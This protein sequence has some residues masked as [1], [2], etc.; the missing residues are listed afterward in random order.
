GNP[1]HLKDGELLPKVKC[2]EIDGG[3]FVLTVYTANVPVEEVQN[4]SANISAILNRK[5]ERYAVTIAN[6]D[7]AFNYVKFTIE[8]VMID[9]SYHFTD[10]N[11]MK[12][13]R[14]INI[15]IQE[16]THIDLT[17]S[18]S[19][20]VAGK[21]RS[22]KTT[23]IISILIQV[24]LQGRDE[25]GS[26]VTIIDPKRAELSVLPHT[27]TVDN[28]GEA[29]AILQALKSF[30][31]IMTERQEYLN[32]LSIQYGD[33][34]HWWDF[35]MRPCF[36]FIDEYVACRSLFPKKAEKN[37]DYCLATFDALIKRIVTMGASAGSHVIISIA[38]ASVDEGGLPTMLK[39]AMSTKIL[40]R[41]TLTEG[42]LMWNSEKLKTFPER[43]YKQ[44]DAW[45]SSTDGIHDDVSFVHF[46][47]MD[48]PVY[49]EL[50]RLLKEYYL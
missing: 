21:T 2:S 17:T 6:A 50:G 19:M 35:D 39:N 16:D 15:M 14:P 3:K 28:D 30:A 11:Q 25:F 5:L 1:L 20:L 10:V 4:L 48:F 40:F 18:G 47:Y 33:A 42:R 22:G 23:G 44:G 27:V 13:D 43:V 46:P 32:K 45:F 8:D 49:K 12:T 38:E 7:I 29:T 34:M 37:S 31:Q 9:K 36:L 26:N 24:L 41:P